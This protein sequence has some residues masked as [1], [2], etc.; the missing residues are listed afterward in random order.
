V[1]RELGAVLLSVGLGVAAGAASAAAQE[2]DLPNGRYPLGTFSPVT[3][4]CS[5]LPDGSVAANPNCVGYYDG[6]V[7]AVYLAAFEGD[8]LYTGYWVSS[9]SGERCDAEFD[10]SLYWG[11]VSFRF[12]DL[13]ESWT[14][15][16]GFCNDAPSRVW[17][18]WR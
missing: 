1:K 10:G 3:F 12:D 13:A 18:G 4:M 9:V 11:R 17:D 7:S 16:W 5:A 6:W 2:A 8:G 15:E 14:G